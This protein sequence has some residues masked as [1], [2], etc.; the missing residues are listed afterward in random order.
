MEVCDEIEGENALHCDTVAAAVSI[1][2]CDIIDGDFIF[3]LLC[4]LLWY[5]VSGR[6]GYLSCSLSSRVC[7]VLKKKKM[8]RS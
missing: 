2:A 8:K 5:L 1:I 4:F 3:L 7:D 6:C